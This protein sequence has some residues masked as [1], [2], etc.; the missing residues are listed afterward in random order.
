MGNKIKANKHTSMKKLV[1]I[2]GM[3]ALFC[4]CYNDK[5]DKLYPVPVTTCDTTTITYSHDIA[6]IIANYCLSPGN[7]CHDV[8]GAGVSGYDYQTNILALQSNAAT[9]LLL[10]DINWDPRHN[11]MPKNAAKLPDCDINKITRWVN[12]GAQ[13]N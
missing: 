6:P 8:T 5:Y 11:A 1:P 4:G 10:P 13:N 9:G 12:Q 3:L 2:V 7:G